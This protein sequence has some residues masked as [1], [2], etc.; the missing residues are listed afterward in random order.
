MENTP[1]VIENCIVRDNKGTGIQCLISIPSIRN[2]V[3]Y[4][5]DGPYLMR[6]LRISKP[7]S[8]QHYR[9]KRLRRIYALCKSEVWSATIFFSKFKSMGLGKDESESQELFSTNSFGIR[10]PKIFYEPNRHKRISDRS[11]LRWADKQT[12]NIYNAKHQR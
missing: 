7:H 12:F 5:T 9:R 6:V 3:I 1:P 2:C 4:E 8:T 11:L 10:H